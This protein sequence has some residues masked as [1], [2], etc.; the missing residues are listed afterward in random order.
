[1]RTEP[2]TNYEALVLGLK[3]AITAPS[4]EQAKEC[5]KILKKLDVTELEIELAKKEVAGG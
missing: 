5:I 2:Q 1:M 4:E 3:L